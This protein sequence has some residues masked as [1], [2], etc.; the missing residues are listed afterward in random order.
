M[1]TII[2]TRKQSTHSQLDL[3]IKKTFEETLLGLN[4]VSVNDVGAAD[5]GVNEYFWSHV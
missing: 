5:L 1:K 2:P 4:T 3:K